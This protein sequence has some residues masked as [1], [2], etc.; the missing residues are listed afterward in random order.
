VEL[1]AAAPINALQIQVG[2]SLSFLTLLAA[3]AVIL[4]LVVWLLLGVP[5][6]GN[7]LWAVVVIGLLGLVAVS[8]GFIIA[9]ISA[10]ETQTVQLA[11]L[12][13]LFSVFFGGLFIPVASLAMPVRLVGL[14]VP[15]THAGG[16]LRAVMLRGEGVPF[17]DM[18]WLVG[19]AVVVVP[20]S[21]LAFRTQLRL[22][23]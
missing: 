6:I 3:V 8:V 20:L 7:P 10:T 9:T 14:L 4:V 21:Y 23:R 11:M 19:T 1:F 13:L 18:A 16:G 5:F 22:G 2:K 12:V 17:D 15:V